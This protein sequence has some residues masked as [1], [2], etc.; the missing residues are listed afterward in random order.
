MY[1]LLLFEI[2][3]TVRGYHFL[4]VTVQSVLQPMEDYPLQS[5]WEG[6]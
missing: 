2:V 5:Q 4:W 3:Q 6:I 1:I